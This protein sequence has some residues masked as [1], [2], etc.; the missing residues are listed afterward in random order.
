MDKC[1]RLDLKNKLAQM[2]RIQPLKDIE[3]VSASYIIIFIGANAS[4]VFYYHKDVALLFHYQTD[5]K[6]FYQL[7]VIHEKIFFRIS[8]K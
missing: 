8:V 2:Q 5:S 7:I 3:D 4:E 1:F 6:Y